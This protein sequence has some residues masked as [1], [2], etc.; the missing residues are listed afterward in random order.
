MSA[1]LYNQPPLSYKQQLE[2]LKSRGLIISDEI[3][4]LHLL[5]TISY[6]RLSGYWYPLLAH[7]KS[8]K[9]FKPDVSFDNIFRLYCFDRELRRLVSS[10]LEKIE[11]AIRAKMIYVL[12]HSFG[13]FWFSNKSLF[14]NNEDLKASLKKLETERDRSDEIYIKTFNLNYSNPLPPSWMMLEI[15]SFGNLSSFY[16][17]LKAGR[18]K[19]SIA[20]HFGLDEHVF[21]SWIHCLVYVRN[22]CAHHARLWNRRLSITPKIPLNPDGKWIKITTLP[23]EN[24]LDKPINSRVFFLLSMIVFLLNTIN[25]S[26]TFKEKLSSL[27]EK[28][29]VIDT[30]AMG[31]PPNWQ[32]EDL[33]RK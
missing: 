6:F 32:T 21:E 3:K 26:H 13:P 28:Y 11:I 20:N 15:S 23:H 22:I 30:R 24:K 29:P 2:Q 4:A 27:L 17:N 10:E 7:P 19:R 8:N 18:D 25:P 12:S 9:L 31:F 33:W 1:P 16:L 5:E 14:K